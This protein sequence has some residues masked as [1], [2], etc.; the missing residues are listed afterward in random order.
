LVVLAVA[1]AAVLV[2]SQSAC[3]SSGGVQMATHAPPRFTSSATTPDT[4]AEPAAPRP[5]PTGHTNLRVAVLTENFFDASRNRRLTTVVRYPA[6]PPGGTSAGGQAPP[7]PLIVFGHG[8]AVTPAPY[9]PL[10][11]AWVRAGYVVAAPIF[12]LGNENAPGG[13]NEHDLPNQPTDMNFVITKM[14]ELSSVGGGGPLASVISSHVAV[15]GQSDGGDTALATAFDPAAHTLPIGAAAI[16]SGAEDPFAPHFTPQ[17]GTPLLAVQGTADNVNLPAETMSY[18]SA[19]AP[20][21]FLLLLNGAG[22]QEPY[23]APGQTLD[24]VAKVTTA[25]FDRYLKRDG[26]ELH[27]YAVQRTA[28]AG[29]HFQAYE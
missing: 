4:T 10:L 21:K 9:T 14:L 13:P 16:L 11:D 28:G 7:Y 20:P 22:H 15:A 25:F 6:P 3:G 17:P 8:F 19:A 18:F 26:S 27:H 23:T 1:A 24:A 29:T 2:L 5:R 12:P